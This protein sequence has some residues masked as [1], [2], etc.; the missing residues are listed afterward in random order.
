[1]N[2]HLLRVVLKRLADEFERASS[3][4]RKE[5]KRKERKQ[6]SRK[7]RRFFE[8]RLLAMVGGTLKLDCRNM[9]I[10]LSVAH[11]WNIW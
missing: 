5:G 2:I 11:G 10:D 3:K 4:R 1:M 9:R 6:E 8:W 7:S